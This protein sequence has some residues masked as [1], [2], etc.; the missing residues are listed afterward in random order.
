M[1]ICQAAFRCG[2]RFIKS[3]RSGVRGSQDIEA[4]NVAAFGKVARV[5]G[6]LDGLLRVAP[7]GGFVR[8]Q[9]QCHKVECLDV[10]RSQT[11]CLTTLLDGLGRPPYRIQGL[12]PEIVRGG[13]VR[14]DFN[15]TPVVLDGFGRPIQRREGIAAVVLGDK[16]VGVDACC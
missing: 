1:A 2:Y 12:S 11:E 16:V 8:S 13:V 10:V 15:G 6:E 14:L 7:F 3:A 9:K 5:L 4:G